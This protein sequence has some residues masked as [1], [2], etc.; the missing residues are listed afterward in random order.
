MWVVVDANG[1]LSP[2]LHIGG[3]RM[4]VPDGHAS[5]NLISRS[6]LRVSVPE[7]AVRA[8]VHYTEG[9]T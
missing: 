1:A 4:R 9:V 7:T 8:T 5:S 3:N 2:A 6:H